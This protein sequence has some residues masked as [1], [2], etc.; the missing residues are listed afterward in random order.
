MMEHENDQNLTLVNIGSGLEIA[1][2]DKFSLRMG[3]RVDQIFNIIDRLDNEKDKL[4]YL[5]QLLEMYFKHGAS[6]DRLKSSDLQRLAD[7]LIKSR[8]NGKR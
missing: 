8:T 1:T 3:K 7:Q 6:Y 5:I 2:K 4:K